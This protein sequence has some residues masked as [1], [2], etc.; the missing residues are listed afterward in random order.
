[1]ENAD[2]KVLW[3]PV[4]VAV[5]AG[6]AGERALAR[7]IISFCVHVLL[8]SCSVIFFELFCIE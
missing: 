6:A 5:S 4:A 7:T 2:I 8:R 3:P 1:M